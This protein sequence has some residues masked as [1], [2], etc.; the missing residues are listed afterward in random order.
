MHPETWRMEKRKRRRGY[1]MSIAMVE[2]RTTEQ[3]KG[4]GKA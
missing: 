3:S 2:Q 4:Q 1:R